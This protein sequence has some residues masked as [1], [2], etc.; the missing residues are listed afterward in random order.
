MGICWPEQGTRGD[1]IGLGQ[2]AYGIER[3]GSTT[4][5]DWGGVWRFRQMRDT[6]NNICFEIHPLFANVPTALR[7]GNV[8]INDIYQKRPWVSIRVDYST[9]TQR[10]TTITQ[11]GQKT[12][13]VDI[14][15][16]GFSIGFDAHP[17]GDTY[18]VS[19]SYR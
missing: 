8:D 19:C 12:A 18:V 3:G 9:F 14:I 6:F 1:A 7:V 11:R 16:N 2:T 4:F 5:V 15:N 13:T 10:I 17:H